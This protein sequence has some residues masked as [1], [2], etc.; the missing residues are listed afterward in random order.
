MAAT[1]SLAALDAAV[2]RLDVAAYTVPTD[3]PES[4]GTLEW[5]STTIVVV[6]AHADGHTG[7]GYTYCDAAAAEV[8]SSQ[9]AGV[10]EGEDA[11]DVRAAWLRMWGQVRF[12][13]G[14][15]DG[16]RELVLD[17]PNGRV[18]RVRVPE[19]RQA[20]GM[21]LDDDDRRRVPLERAVRL[22][23]VRRDRV[24]GDL[25]AFDRDVEARPFADD[26][27]VTACVPA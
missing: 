5:D 1:A 21:R 23:R 27:H 18:V 10:V 9:L 15:A 24:R 16:R 14:S 25:D 17:Q 12:D 4:D 7:L 26:R 6:E 20:P 2:E 11:M 13:L 22:G 3:E 19:P 8:I